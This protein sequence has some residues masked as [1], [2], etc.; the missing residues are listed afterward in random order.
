MHPVSLLKDTVPASLD[1][2]SDNEHHCS[3]KSCCQF[4]TLK[5]N[6]SEKYVTW[7]LVVSY[8]KHLV[9]TSSSQKKEVRWFVGGGPTILR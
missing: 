9:L 1:L 4:F 5:Y 3:K 2:F 6:V 7:G 8:L